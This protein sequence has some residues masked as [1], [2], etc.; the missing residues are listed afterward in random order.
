MYATRLLKRQDDARRERETFLTKESQRGK[1]AGKYWKGRCPKNRKEVTRPSPDL[2]RRR[3]PFYSGSLVSSWAF[4]LVSIASSD[5]G[6][7]SG[8]PTMIVEGGSPA[9]IIASSW[10]R[11]L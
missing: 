7:R 5:A 2:R 11:V 8:T 4:S 10:H 1:A 3:R 6:G 9:A